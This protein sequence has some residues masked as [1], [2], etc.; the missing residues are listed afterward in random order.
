MKPI[1]LI[2]TYNESKSIK[3]ILDGIKNINESI[4]VLIIDDNSPDKTAD[5]VKS[6][7]FSNVDILHRAQK[8]GLGNAYK[9]AIKKILQSD[10][11]STYTHLI[12][13]D[14]DGSHRPE[15][16]EKMLKISAAN[17]ES[18]IL[19]SRWISGGAI[20]NW[21]SH[22]KWLSK[23]GTRYAKWALKMQIND[24]TGGFRIYPREVLESID[25][26][27][28]TSNGYCYQIEM[29]FALKHLPNVQTIEVPITFVEREQGESKMSQRIVL[30]AM[31]KVTKLG[32]GLRLR[33]T[34]DKLHY[35]K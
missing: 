10:T 12:S 14:A 24:L 27:Q 19:G 2:P 21:P 30:E 29:A 8:D 16:L 26:D 31:L 20:V 11:Y 32:I 5:Y 33:P 13:M 35:V 34:A 17:P 25:L 3:E 7:D 18:F 28:I 15:D 9:A 22:R 1:V 23:A 6:L 4:D